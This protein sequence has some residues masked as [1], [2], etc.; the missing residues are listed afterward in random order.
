MT[1]PAPRSVSIA[2]GLAPQLIVTD[3]DGT[4]LMP[5][6]SVSATNCA[7]VVA[8]QEAGVPVLFATGRPVRWLD[9]VRDLP[10]AH[11]TVIASNGA[12]LY[13]L[14]ADVVLDRI[15]IDP[16]VALRT[17]AALREALPGTSFAFESGTRFGHEPAYRTAISPDQV[18]AAMFCG[19]A[20]EI[21]HATPFVKMLVQ[22]DLVSPDE[23]AALLVD[24]VGDTL[25]VTHSA[26]A[27]HG[28]V[29]VSAP[30]V[31]K[32]SMLMRVCAQL[33]VP[34][35]AVAAF[36]DMPN[37]L[38]MLTWVGMPRVVANAHP[39][40][41]DLGFPV[42]GSNVDSGVGRTIVDWLRSVER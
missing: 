10:G 9:V 4:F 22:N 38:D 36:G 3:L 11:P 6:G 34:R 32:A 20:E 23:L 31:S 13:D 18:K 39:A 35:A 42:V 29:E 16:Q 17:A 21:A 19:P 24:V 25:T 7:A 27:D 5:D 33:G 30:G 8:A 12:V 14:G 1:S 2:A 26:R 37:D 40:L 15:C 41:L 28:L